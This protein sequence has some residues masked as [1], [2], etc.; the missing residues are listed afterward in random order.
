MV[1]LVQILLGFERASNPN[2]KQ[3]FTPVLSLRGE[4]DL[5]RVRHKEKT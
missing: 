4:K 1:I 3:E 5:F 2:P